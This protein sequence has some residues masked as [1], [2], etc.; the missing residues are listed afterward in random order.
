MT[1]NLPSPETLLDRYFVDLRMNNWSPQT[2]D[3]RSISI[4][5]FLRWCAER[6]IDC[7]TEIT[8]E[9]IAAYRHYLFHHVSERT[10]K[11]IKFSTQSEYLAAIAHW[12]SWLV[13]QGHIPSNPADN[14]G[15]PKEE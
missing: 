14:V 8:D 7:V 6:C 12:M 13:E 1:K 9:V 11:P 5:V 4:R 3:C 10:G 15:R 2:I